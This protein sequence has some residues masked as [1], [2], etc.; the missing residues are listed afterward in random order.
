MARLSAFADEAAEDFAAQV[1]FLSR[2]GIS[3]LELRL[4]NGQNIMDLNRRELAQTRLMLQDHGIK[5]SAIGSPIGKVSLEEPF[6]QHQEKFK[7]AVELASYFD[8]A[9][10]RIFSYFAPAGRNI[11]ACREEVMER[12]AA[13]VELLKKSD[14]TL[15]H[16]N[17]AN[18]YG[19][20]PDRCVDIVETINSPRLRLAYDPGNFVQNE[21][22]I[23]NMDICW[24]VMKDYV[25]HVHIKDRKVDAETGCL[26][27]R[28]D[29]QIKELLAELAKI[30]YQGFLTLEPHMAVSGVFSG[31][32]GPELFSQAIAAV[33]E[34][35]AETGLS[36]A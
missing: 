22:I 5:I 25:V 21:R 12:L 28:G 8:T 33:R 4:V 30:N 3:Y 15:V 14:I 32:S 35:A 23:N 27:G 9:L 31:F 34:I 2:E 17:E 1:D 36:C 26:P 18:I 13:Q 29:G 24:P 16:E 19:Q 7:H 11:T 10:I 6:D 20:T